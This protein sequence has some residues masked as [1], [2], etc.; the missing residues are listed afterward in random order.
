MK[1][2]IVNR[3]T[4]SPL[5]VID[6]EDYYDDIPRLQ[7]DMAEWLEDGLVL[8]EQPFREAL[9][10]REWSI[11]QNSYVAICCSSDAIIPAWASMLVASYLAPFALKIGYGNVEA[12]DSSIFQTIL[13]NIDYSQYNGKPVIV[14]G[15]AN[16][17]IPKTAFVQLI[18]KIRPVAKSVMFGEA[19]SSVP[20]FKNNK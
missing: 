16:K 10:Q 18:E 1:E 19:C 5:V 20:L 15:C 9:K 13:E 14:K 2:S 4:Q 7:V 8:R 6:L 3:V 12:L 17:P 11:F